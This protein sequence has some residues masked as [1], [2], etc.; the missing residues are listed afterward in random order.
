MNNNRDFSCLD[1]EVVDYDAVSAMNNV[2]N[3]ND[4]PSDFEYSEA[5]GIKRLVKS[6]F[7]NA[8]KRVDV[9]MQEAYAKRDMAKAM[10][11]DTSSKD[12]AN[13]LSQ[14]QTTQPQS[15]GLSTVAKIGI[16]VGVLAVLTVITIVVVKSMKKNKKK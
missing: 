12:I 5:G 16:G 6:T 2:Q 3:Y 13:A 4:L 7:P 15:S 11:N 9:K 1:G 8:G 10:L 14:P